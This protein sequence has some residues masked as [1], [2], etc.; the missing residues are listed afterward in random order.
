ME[1][2]IANDLSEREFEAKV[3]EGLKLTY[4]K[5]VEQHR[6]DNKPL[7]FSENGVVQ[8]VDPYSVQI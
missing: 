1:P 3:R 4:R 7:V 5:V 8:F 6:R 2:F